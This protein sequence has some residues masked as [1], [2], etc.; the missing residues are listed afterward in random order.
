MQNIVGMKSRERENLMKRS[1]LVHCQ[2]HSAKN[3][4][5][6]NLRASVVENE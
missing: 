3:Q 4:D 1:K 5:L 2:Y 6:S